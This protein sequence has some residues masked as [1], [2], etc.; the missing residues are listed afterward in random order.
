MDFSATSI[1]LVYNLVD[2]DSDAYK[3]LFQDTEYQSI[4]RSLIR[5]K[6]VWKQHPSNYYPNSVVLHSYYYGF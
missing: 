2:N 5:G 1:N 4:M 3:A 6:G